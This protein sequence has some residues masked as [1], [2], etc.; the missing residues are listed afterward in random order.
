MG[1]GLGLNNVIIAAYVG[2][3][4]HLLTGSALGEYLELLGSDGKKSRCLIYS[5]IRYLVWGQVL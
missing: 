2:F 1:I 3:G 4:L 5:R